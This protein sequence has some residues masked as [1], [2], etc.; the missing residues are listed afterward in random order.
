MTNATHPAGLIP[1]GYEQITVSTV[2]KRLNV[3]AGA[4]RAV[5]GVEAQ[6]IRYR[7]DGQHPTSSV[8]FLV[9][10]DVNF[11]VVG[12][13]ALKAL[14]L[15]RQGSS[16]ATLNVDYY[17]EVGTIDMVAVSSPS[18]SVSPSS[19]VSP[20]VSPSSSVSPSA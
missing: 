8:G 3:P 19:S 16:D 13:L 7:S 5:V 18:A 2:V 14:R 17:K 20:S 12:A 11:E 9:K 1:A 15:I 10:A 4:V 6:P